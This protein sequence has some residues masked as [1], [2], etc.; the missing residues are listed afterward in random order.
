MS[1]DMQRY[2]REI[3][4][5][6]EEYNQ[7]SRNID[8]Y[9]EK[10]VHLSLEIFTK[11]AKISNLPIQQV[12]LEAVYES[13]KEFAGVLE[14]TPI[15]VPEFGNLEISNTFGTV[16]FV[17]ITRSTT[18]FKD[19]TLYESY[20]EKENYTGFVIFNSYITLT[21]SITHFFNGEF[22]E[23]TGDGAMLFFKED[24]TSN[25]DDY[26]NNPIG[27]SFLAGEVLKKY[28]KE[29]GLIDYASETLENRS[30][31]EKIREPSLIHI[32]A[33]YGKVL[34]VSLGGMK[35]LI[36]YTVWKAA[37]NCKEADRTVVKEKNFF[38]E[39][40]YIELPIK[41]SQNY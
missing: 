18:Y 1:S 6:S 32:G 21:K 24:V 41:I 40:E 14:K 13:V 28:A 30:L 12:R 17:D 15:S 37:N 39:T 25:Y 33:S 4:N 19:K 31:Y 20:S 38:G 23:H 7:Y 35:K 27:L 34:N 26:Y 5:L 16:V 29:K 22:L 3:E 10:C 8:K 36:S 11:V 9:L 2:I